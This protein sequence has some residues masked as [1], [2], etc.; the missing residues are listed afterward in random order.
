MVV[1]QLIVHADVPGIG[2]IGDIEAGVARVDC[3]ESVAEPVAES[4]RVP[5]SE[6]RRVT[7]A[8]QTRVFWLDPSTGVWR[9]GRVIGGGPASGYFVRLPNTDFDFPAAEADLRVRWDRP[10]REPHLVLATGGHES[11][12]FRN[13]RLP[14]L[15]SLIDQRAACASVPA[16]LSSAVE[17]YPHQVRAVIA[18]LSDPIRRYLLADE[19]G[20]G[21]TVEAGVIVRQTLLDNPTASVV[22][23]APEPLRRQWSR[24]LTDKFF[25]DDFPGATVTITSHA[26]PDRWRDYHGADLVVVDEAHELVAVED[27]TESPYRQLCGLA[28]STPALLLMSAT[29]ATANTLMYL[30]LLHLLDRD[31]YRWDDRAGFQRR[32]ELRKDLASA[33]YALSATFISSLP[34]TIEKIAALVPGDT[35]FLDLA[36]AALSLLD[37]EGELRDEAAAPELAIRV[38]SMR[39]HIS[40]TYRLHRRVIRH[41]RARVLVDDETTD[42]LPYEVRGRSKPAPIEVDSQAQWIVAECLLDWQSQ[43]RDWLLDHDDTQAPAYGM[44]LAILASRAGCLP[45]DFVDVLRWRTARDEEAALRARLT[46]YEQHAL[47]GPEIIDRELRLLEQLVRNL[48]EIDTRDQAELLDSLM[49]ALPKGCRVVVF[50]GPGAMASDLA[51]LLKHRLPTA[52]VGEHTARVGAASSEQAVTAWQSP[53]PAS[54]HRILVADETADDGL[55]LQTADIVVHCRLPWNPNRLEQRLGRVDRYRGP[56]SS[57][58]RQPAKQFVLTD[59]T[60]TDSLLGA[61][62]TQL[63]DGFG[64]FDQSISALQDAVTRTTPSVWCAAVEHGPPGLLETQ[65][66][67]REDMERE[68]REIDRLDMLESIHGT[69]LEMRDIAAS[70]TELEQDW[71]G[72]QAAMLG[73]VSDD[74]G[75]QRFSYQVLRQ[76]PPERWR[77]LPSGEPLIPPRLFRTTMVAMPSQAREATFN[78]SA[79]LTRPGTRLFRQGNPVLDLLATVVA[80]DDRGQAA[81]F[82]RYDQR[83]RGGPDIYFGFDYLV[84]A[85]IETAMTLLENQPT[86]S[87]AV[88]RQADR[89]FPPFMLRTWVS[90]LRY[91]S[92]QGEAEIAWLDAP[93]DKAKG[94]RNFNSMSV[95]ELHNLFQGAQSFSEAV[96]QAQA[97]ARKALETTTDLPR[98]CAE[99]QDHARKTM[100]VAQ[101]QALARQAAGRLVG[102]AG[103]YVAD[104]SL[105]GA[106]IDGLSEPAV[107]QVGAI[108]IVRT[109]LTRVSHGT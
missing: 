70:L 58:Q 64:V 100:A 4:W 18:V 44:V 61:W 36:S 86:A 13:S 83:Y 108:C 96:S 26:T 78:R 98:R 31:L 79:A 7:L 52:S 72:I 47:A 71:R 74:D 67:V 53:V 43:V 105:A 28:H 40:E 15:K 1:G 22:V 81:A 23:L 9:V 101:A 48:A 14:M 2:R 55:N 88:R 20:L 6:C 109:G 11:G 92:I 60:H 37:D 33:T 21:K 17:I 25:I 35:G 76:Q 45:S 93:Y 59:T 82:R 63:R 62:L 19:V 84:E 30:G 46:P 66:T 12:Y 10:V 90:A 73:Y 39:A 85:D 5:A 75:G 69:A 38:E 102:D 87:I 80:I 95:G 104:V 89:I 65:R 103:S 24:E 94:D 91:E 56:E 32:Y 42:Q 8:A 99:A 57:S 49:A 106:L 51:A 50:C 16:I 34:S 68:L 107:R 41:R 3:F 54:D 29:P 77:F 27:P 97:A